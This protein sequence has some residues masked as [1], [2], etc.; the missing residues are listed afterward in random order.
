MSDYEEELKKWEAGEYG[1]LNV[2]MQ[3]AL[4]SHYK[5]WHNAEETVKRLEALKKVSKDDV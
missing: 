4:Y 1:H 3:A 5:G 2:P